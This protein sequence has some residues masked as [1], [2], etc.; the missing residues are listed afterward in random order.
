MDNNI[1]FK[2]LWQKQ[3]VGQGDIEEVIKKVNHYKRKSLLKL[4][5]SNVLLIIT[6][7]VLILIWIYFQPQFI[8]TKIGIII[9]ILAM[10]VF[11]YFYNR[12]YLTLK[13]DNETKNNSTFLK[14]L[15]K[16]KTQQKQLQTIILKI[17][18]LMLSIGICLYLYEYVYKMSTILAVITYIVTAT[19]IAFNW[20][21]LRP[22]IIKKQELKLNDLIK[23]FQNI[24]SQLKD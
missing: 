22:K 18:F 23:K 10:V 21:Y 9:T 24:E 1:D 6:S 13:R 14:N 11:I 4:I 20:F 15:N 7:V 19:W 3:Q 5:I 17:Y 16:L 12:Q 8:T 2:Q